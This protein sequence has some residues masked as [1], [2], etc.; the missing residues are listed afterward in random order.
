ME[1]PQQS[2]QPRA[3]SAGRSPP[4]PPTVSAVQRTAEIVSS[5]VA[6]AAADAA[7]EQLAAERVR[8]MAQPSAAAQALAAAACRFSPPAPSAPPAAPPPL[9]PRRHSGAEHVQRWTDCDAELARIHAAVRHLDPAFGMGSSGASAV[10]PP[11]PLPP[12]MSG[13]GGAQQQHAGGHSPS[14]ASEAGDS[15]PHAGP[16]WGAHQERQ[17]DDTAA[18]EQPAERDVVLHRA[19]QAARDGAAAAAALR[20]ELEA[21]RADMRRLLVQREEAAQAARAA[22]QLAAM[23]EAEAAAAVQRLAQAEAMGERHTLERRHERQRH[24]EMLAQREEALLAAQKQCEQLREADSRTRKQSGEAAQRKEQLET[25]VAQQQEVIE[26]FESTQQQMQV[27]LDDAKRKAT[28]AAAELAAL[29]DRCK[30][31]EQR[32]ERAEAGAGAVGD[33]RAELHVAQGRESAAR[34]ALSAAEEVMAELRSRLSEVE[35]RAATQVREARREA[36]EARGREAA[37]RGALAA[38]TE[39]R[40]SLRL[41]TVGAPSA[42]PETLDERIAEKEGEL[43]SL[44]ALYRELVEDRDQLVVR[45]RASESR[46]AAAGGAAAEAVR[47]A[48]QRLTAIAA[49]EQ[50]AADAENRAEELE[51]DLEAERAESSR[52]ADRLVAMGSA[53]EELLGQLEALRLENAML[54]AQG[55]QSRSRS[56]VRQ[57]PQ[58]PPQRPSAAMALGVDLDAR[59]LTVAKVAK[60]SP[61]AFAG[62]RRGDRVAW[63]RQLPDGACV[64]VD[65]AQVLRTA[66]LI[67]REGSPGGGAAR[68]Q[69]GVVREG[70]SVC[71]T[72][73]L[74]RGDSGG[75]PRAGAAR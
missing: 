4:V 37:A 58:L 6:H 24:E 28:A 65:C 3:R 9:P 64:E 54:A 39:E 43:D 25:E 72:A 8:S 35:E 32:A 48:E 27:E 22:A 46:S 51:R 2:P 42:G 30:T 62:L 49:A 36:Q 41:R 33:L 29:T 55:G 69:F 11:S 14:N 53:Q 75:S 50:R 67:A 13:S 68:L 63:V 56:P 15:A 26:A 16:W 71:C 10:T 40:D 12:G 38:A 5:A 74:P 60:G 20:L 19:L 45:L 59:Q 66:L 47:A 34:G 44:R 1:S 31:A 52:R 17:S 7:W 61:A 70:R 21:E 23:R 73:T 18:G 57:Q